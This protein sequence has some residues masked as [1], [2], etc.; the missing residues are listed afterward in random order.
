MSVRPHEKK[1]ELIEKVVARVHEK[2]PRTHMSEVE[3]F[4]RRYYSP[5]APEDLLDWD[6]LDLY[7]ASLAH[8]NLLLKRPDG[9]PNI[10]V[11]NPQHEAHGWQSTHTIVEIVT[12][13]MPFLVDSVRMELNRHGL[14]VHLIIHPIMRVARDDEGQLLRLL[15]APDEANQGIDEAIMH[16]EVDRQTDPGYL[17]KLHHHLG[18]V[19]GDV[20]KA[21]EDWPKMRE[22]L[23][24]ILAH[25]DQNPPP[26]DPE[27]LAEACA[28]LKWID[29]DHYVPFTFLGYREYDLVS[30]NGQDVLRIVP[31]SGLG[32]LRETHR[33]TVSHSFS[34]LPPEVRKLARLP[35]LLILTKSN[36]RT[37]VYRPGYED[38]LG[39]KRF[40]AEGRVV[41]ER[42]FIGLYAASA[43]NSS[44]R[45]IPILRRK[46]KNVFERSGLSPK[47]HSGRALLNILETYPRNDLFQ[48]PEDE[49][50]EI[51]LGIL[52]LGQHQR[53][54]LFM[55]KDPYGRFLSCLVFVP[56]DHFNTEVRLRM[57]EMLKHQ[58]NATSVEFNVMLSESVLARLEFTVRL[59]PGELPEYDVREL[60][61]QLIDATQTWQDLLKS[62][63]LGQLG[64]ATGNRLFQRYSEAFPAGYREDF[65][66]RTAV[67][68]I[69]M[70]EALAGSDDLGMSLYRPLEA[71][72]GWLRFKLF[73]LSQ[74]M[75]LSDALPMLENM[76]VTVVDERPYE[77]EP[78]GIEPAGGTPVWIYNFGLTHREKPEFDATEI[79]EIFQDT[80]AKVW[81]GEVEND[82]FN[83]LVLGARLTWREITVLRAYC[84]YLR[85]SGL[86]FSQA[87]MEQ[88][89]S[90]NPR[91]ARRLVDLFNAR[92]DP[93]NLSKASSHITRLTD[94]LQEDLEA[95]VSLDEDRILRSF[96]A[97]IQATLRT[98]HFQSL[99][100]GKP[101]S[102]LSF[103]FNPQL[104]P[105]LPEPRPMF[106]IFVYSPRVEGVHLRGGKVARGGVRW[107]DRREDYRTEILGLLKAQM[108]KNAVI[109]PMGAKGGFVVKRLPGGAD[110]EAVIQEVVACYRTFIR[111]LLDLTDNLVGGKVVPPRE[112]VR[113][114]ADD[115]YLVV[116]ADKGTA[117][118]SDFANE[119]AREYGFWLGDAFASGGSAGYDHKK[120]GITARGTWE[121]VKQHF[122][123][124]HRDSETTEFTV[125]GIGDM[126]G[127]VF[128]NATLQSRHV[129]LIGAFDHRHIFIDPNP[130]PELSFQER[131]RLFHLPRSSWADYEVRLIS[132]GGGIF[133]RTAKSIRLS[134]EMKRLLST[135]ADVLTP[136]ALIRLLL[137]APVDLLL[138]GGIGTFVKASSESHA[139]AQDKS[140]DAVRIDA[141]ELCCAVVAEGGNLGFTQRSRIEYARAGGR[142]NTDFIDNSGGVDC[143]DHEVNI[144]ILLNEVVESGDMTE[145]Q[146]NQLLAQM[147]EEIA[148]L[149]LKNTYW[150]SRTISLEEAQALPLLDEHLRFIRCLERAGKLDRALEHLPNDEALP[151]RKAAGE[152]LTRPEISVLIAY[153]KNFLFEA[154]LASDLPEDP[155]ISR[156]F[157]RYFPTPLRQ[158]FRDRLHTHR[159]RREIIATV[160]TNRMLN[161]MGSTFVFS[162]QEETGAGAAD[163]VRAYTVAWEVFN[164]H[165]LWSDIAG[166]DNKVPGTVQTEMMIEGIRLIRRASLWFLRNRRRPLDVA[167]C[168]SQFATGAALLAEQLSDL[169]V[170]AHREALAVATKHLVEHGVPQ[171]LAMRVV[172]LDA[173]YSMDIVEVA[174]AMGLPVPTV[175]GVYFDLGERLKLHWLHEQVTALAVDNHWQQRARDALGEDVFTLQKALTREALRL[176]EESTSA[177]ARVASWII[178]VREPVEHCLHVFADL[179]TGVSP[180]LA[181]LSV[182]LRE[183]H[184]LLQASAALRSLTEVPARLERQ[185]AQASVDRACVPSTSRVL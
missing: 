65:P 18:R 40:D 139:E 183:L 185:A 73:H 39:V 9:K 173:L 66:A 87:Y 24:E 147:T 94:E 118:F 115:P 146:R 167:A 42:R 85:Q 61:A 37:T 166:L 59:A 104:V 43:Y 152:G 64:E 89:L 86:T 38:Y 130:D 142:I 150:Q 111:G 51:A 62:A 122:R 30:E 174:N 149:V 110:R 91:I 79:K 49:L 179:K 143:S 127:D 170:P 76:G 171:P 138:N 19:L 176:E 140:N 32:I 90:A 163:I 45:D 120:M 63:L 68:D 137:K 67:H 145:K 88:T 158:R 14:T 151:E 1:A 124:L 4:V 7:G 153:A 2:L 21:V 3:A 23:H 26:L 99:R 159:L 178:H 133:P 132:K 47:G 108:V 6:V 17:E 25:L 15:A 96:L 84:K 141:T 78:A 129:K 164:M 75:P 156:E 22:K 41:G 8:W 136:N 93:R 10:H 53:T 180:D 169:L 126:S 58:F 55:W 80:F 56:R 33:E 134:P 162:L 101:K 50:L 60:E 114:D 28:F 109:V 46:V 113:Y 98:N 34:V 52:H 119:I 128:G 31:G 16:V 100:D 69:Q 184:N 54:R 157:E 82:G 103:K 125:V 155:Y 165:G 81:R 131:K 102:Y 172:S 117:T 106:E 148:Q 74:P 5:V 71:S 181:M 97:V 161:R 27:E 116:A 95:V 107:S 105:D 77:I 44:P 83:R 154:L 20:R 70:M 57:Q 112:M 12:D 92:F 29:S 13:D 168:I 48:I 177:A 35:E 182:A 144:K 123:E 11:Y 160:V 36:S 175:A 121:S 72:F 135:E